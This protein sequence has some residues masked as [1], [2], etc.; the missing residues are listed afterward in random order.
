[1]AEELQEY[2]TFH[3]KAKDGRDVE[4]AVIDEFDF[5]KAHYVVAAQVID[6]TI[7]EEGQYIYKAILKG[8]DFTVEK[9]RR[10]FDYR[11]IAE[12][13]MEMAEDEEEVEEETEE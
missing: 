1:M 7:S 3:V 9:I 13:Y 8:D 12:A 2:V 5:E 6:D 4:M 10:E 11:R